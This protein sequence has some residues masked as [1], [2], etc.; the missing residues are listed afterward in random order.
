MWSS[1]ES[2]KRSW[3]IADST[4]IFRCQSDVSFLSP[5]S[6]PRILNSPFTFCCQSN[7]GNCMVDIFSTFSQNTRRVWRPVGSIYCN[8]KR[9]FFDLIQQWFTT[10]IGL[11]GSYL[12]FSSDIIVISCAVSFSLSIRIGAFVLDVVFF[13]IIVG[14]NHISSIATM[15]SK[16]AGTINYL[17]FW[18][19][20]SVVVLHLGCERGDSHSSKCI[21]RTTTSL[22]LN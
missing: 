10:F 19:H 1:C 8:S 14:K 22:I 13:A 6:S 18:K 2:D 16:T 4:G 21:A 11:I 7:Q 15:I 12:I 17:L 5:W 3:V 20:L 9:T